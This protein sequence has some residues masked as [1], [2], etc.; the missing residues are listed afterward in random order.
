MKNLISTQNNLVSKVGLIIG[1]E[2]EARTQV[3]M[4]NNLI[5]VP[6]ASL[7]NQ[8]ESA[9]PVTSVSTISKV[10]IELVILT[11]KSSD[12]YFLMSG[13]SNFHP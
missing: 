2:R 13:E 9:Q 11:E 7:A 1:L 6:K 3:L 12:K 4:N 8:T 5:C 10:S